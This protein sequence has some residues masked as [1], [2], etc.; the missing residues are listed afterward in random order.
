MW[1]WFAFDSKALASSILEPA[2]QPV[3]TQDLATWQTVFDRLSQTNPRPHV[4]IWGFSPNATTIITPGRDDLVR[5]Q[6]SQESDFPLRRALQTVVEHC[7]SPIFR[8][9]C[10]SPTAEVHTAPE[11]RRI[12][13]RRR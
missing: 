10:E 11:R 1:E 5:D 6:V 7:A 2:Q 9:R 3:R 13:F 4:S 8:P 12:V